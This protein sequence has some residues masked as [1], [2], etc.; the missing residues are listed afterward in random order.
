MPDD[1]I[2]D[3]ES[4]AAGETP[5]PEEPTAD[6]LT[7]IEPEPAEEPE[8]E[9]VA[10]EPEPEPVAPKYSEDL[11][12]VARKM[13]WRENGEKDP[14]EFILTAQ[15]II[16]TLKGTIGMFKDDQRELMRR[17]EDM[18][19]KFAERNAYETQQTIKRLEAE[20]DQ[21]FESGDKDQFKDINS[22][23]DRLKSQLP[24]ADDTVAPPNRPDKPRIP[25]EVLAE[26]DAWKSENPWYDEDEELQSIANG[27]DAT[28][29][30]R[31]DTWTNKQVL[32]E[33]TKRM[34]RY[35]NP[36][37]TAPLRRVPDVIDASHRPAPPQKKKLD[38]S[39]L[40][41]AQLATFKKFHAMG[42]Y[43]TKQEYADALSEEG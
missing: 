38:A 3:Y 34:Q 41:P 2:P 21:A 23:I 42:L 17:I 40:T 31:H 35:I 11:L 37:A 10:A 9:P 12:T 15:D 43:R 33:V 32:A 26:F 36:P 20:A 22:Q 5:L 8:T 4:V 29:R 27:I 13:G 18:N 39:Q 28:I 24:A 19:R 25:D 30:Q 1:I 6:E 16:K 14:E 7:D